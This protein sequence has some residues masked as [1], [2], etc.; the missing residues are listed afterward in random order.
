MSLVED[1]YDEP[2]EAST[3]VDGDFIDDPVDP[4]DQSKI[5]GAAGLPIDVDLANILTG[6]DGLASKPDAK[7][8]ALA[9]IEDLRSFTAALMAGLGG[10]WSQMSTWI[11]E[12]D[13]LDW[14][15]DL[16]SWLPD[17]AADFAE[18]LAALKGEYA[19]S[20]PV[21]TQIQAWSTDLLTDLWENLD[22]LVSF[23]LDGLG[24]TPAG[25]IWDKILDL[26]DELGDL[27]GSTEDNAAGLSDLIAGL[28]ANPA[29]LLGALPQS[30]ITGL[31]SDLAAKLT[32]TS[33]LN[34]ANLSGVIDEILIPALS[35]SKIT[36]LVSALSGKA[37]AGDLADLEDYVQDFVDAILS[38]IR[39]VPVVGGAIS[40]ILS[41][42]GD[43]KD[44]VDTT[45]SGIV[46]GWNGTGSSTGDVYDTMADI[47]AMLASGYSV[48]T[49]TSSTTWN[50]PAG[51]NELI[52]ICVGGGRNGAAGANASNGNP[53]T[54]GGVGGLGGGFIAQQLDPAA[55]SS[56]VAVTIAAAGGDTSFGSYVTSSPGSG[57]IA[58]QFGFSDTSSK[59]GNG[60]NGGGI[61][62]GTTSS[63]AGVVGGA[64]AL[65][66]GGT[67]SSGNAGGTGGS[68]STSIQ[69]KCGA[70]GGGGGASGSSSSRDGKAGGA[71]GFP[72]GGGGAGG[73]GYYQVFAGSG[74]AAGAG[75]NGVMWIFTK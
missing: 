61:V 64:S 1:W 17:I 30:K 39:K 40:D 6:A 16:S 29:A 22:A 7:A 50:K 44:D 35:Q 55:V 10:D 56:S 36:G 26:G 46:D 4:L 52:V 9:L 8:I 54:A 28:L 41:D 2:E 48:Q 42:V 15:P 60:G 72:G 20:D 74:G 38:A 23:A 27:L 33:P 73:K 75:A 71:G 69:T 43:L 47:K 53:T 66:T 65:A 45:A 37:A 11:D 31:V 24:V 14:L 3:A 34:P 19:G 21:L 5:P 68:V 32:S 18:L 59:P 62:N 70:G 25:S 13:D 49:I 67:A 12:H 63:N 58:T 57:G 51:L